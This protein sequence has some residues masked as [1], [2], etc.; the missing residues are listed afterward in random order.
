MRTVFIALATI[1]SGCATTQELGQSLLDAS[2]LGPRLAAARESRVLTEEKVSISTH[3]SDTDLL[4]VEGRGSAATTGAL[5]EEQMTLAAA[6]KA[7]DAGYRYIVPVSFEDTSVLADYSINR[8]YETTIEANS[9]GSVVGNSYRGTTQAKATTT[10]GPRIGKAMLPGRVVSFKLFESRP[11]GYREGQYFDAA[12]IY[13]N[14]GPKYVDGFQP[15]AV[16][17]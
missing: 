8:P 15:L 6:E 13:N 10:G 4:A 3:W 16:N 14:L 7:L 2:V 12:A 11:D 1:L 17:P 5:V 9:R